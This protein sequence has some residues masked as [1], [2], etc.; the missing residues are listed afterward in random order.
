VDLKIIETYFL[1]LRFIKY[2]CLALNNYKNKLIRNETHG[3]IIKNK[4]N[5]QML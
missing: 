3:I 1:Q 4:T 5:I 2:Y